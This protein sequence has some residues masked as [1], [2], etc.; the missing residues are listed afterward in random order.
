[1]SRTLSDRQ[2][3][4]ANGWTLL[5]AKSSP[6]LY[7]L[8]CS[9]CTTKRLESAER[10]YTTWL[11][12]TIKQSCFCMFAVY[13]LSWIKM[14]IRN[15]ILKLIFRF[16]LVYLIFSMRL[17]ESNKRDQILLS[18][19]RDSCKY[20]QIFDVY[21]QM[22]NKIRLI[23]LEFNVRLCASKIDRNF[24][25][26]AFVFSKL[27]LWNQTESRQTNKQNFLILNLKRTHH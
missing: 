18:S 17:C 20:F 23:F 24:L 14:Y 26:I 10:A 3:W 19:I 4:R 6:T 9:F 13:Y 5:L 1:M 7:Y 27:Q 12:R 16:F 2:V 22:L 8:A 21:L 25:E 11:Y 15:T